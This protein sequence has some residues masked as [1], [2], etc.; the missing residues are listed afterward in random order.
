MYC[1]RYVDTSTFRKLGDII[2][3]NLI[4]NYTLIYQILIKTLL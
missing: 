1:R 3:K 4:V 2:N